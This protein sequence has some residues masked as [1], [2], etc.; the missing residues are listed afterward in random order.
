MVDG[1]PVGSKPVGL[2]DG[3]VEGSSDGEVDGPNEGDNDM[4]GSRVVGAKLGDFEAL[5]D[6]IPL[7]DRDAVANV[8]GFELG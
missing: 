1:V 4:V 3:E 5:L 6:G 7:G 8:V 2:F